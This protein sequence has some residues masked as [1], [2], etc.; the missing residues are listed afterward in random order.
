MWTPLVNMHILVVLCM[1]AVAYAKPEP[2]MI[3]MVRDYSQAI[4]ECCSSAPTSI[5]RTT[6]QL[7]ED[8]QC[9]SPANMLMLVRMNTFVQTVLPNTYRDWNASSHLDVFVRHY[10]PQPCTIAPSQCGPMSSRH[11][12]DLEMWY[13]QHHTPSTDWI[14]CTV[15]AILDALQQNARV[16]AFECDVQSVALL[17]AGM[18]LLWLGWDNTGVVPRMTALEQAVEQHMDNLHERFITQNGCAGR[19]QACTQYVVTRLLLMT[20]NLRNG[21]HDD[22]LPIIDAMMSIV[23]TTLVPH[24]LLDRVQYRIELHWLLL[25]Y[26]FIVVPVR[27]ESS[28]TLGLIHDFLR[29]DD[30]RHDDC[31]TAATGILAKIAGMHRIRRKRKV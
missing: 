25:V 10:Q 21:V 3:W 30:I 13:L 29:Q 4:D 11:M 12:D 8:V 23:E 15:D 27:L 31:M 22:H 2:P 19:L 24:F 26:E 7:H 14:Q 1:L 16:R 28:R 5:D 20:D 17:S 9:E 6:L 18:H